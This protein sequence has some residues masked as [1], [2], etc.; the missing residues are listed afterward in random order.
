MISMVVG[1]HS[2][3]GLKQDLRMARKWSSETSY[4]SESSA[5]LVITGM[6]LF[7]Y[8]FFRDYRASILSKKSVNFLGKD[9]W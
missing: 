4:K 6:Y 2:G 1:L 7:C 5:V 8:Y 9:P 3:R